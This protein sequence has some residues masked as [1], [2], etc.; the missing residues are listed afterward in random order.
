MSGLLEPEIGE[1]LDRMSI[2][3]LKLNV[4]M[5]KNVPTASWEEELRVLDNYLQRKIQGYQRTATSFS[6]DQFSNANARLGI[7]NAKLWEAEDRIR[8]YRKAG[9]LTDSEKMELGEFGLRIADLNDVRAQLVNELNQMFGV[10][11]NTKMY[12]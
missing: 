1:V 6:N 4:G 7:V 10:S 3:Q 11:A 5:R 8:V 2:L 9:S 12:A